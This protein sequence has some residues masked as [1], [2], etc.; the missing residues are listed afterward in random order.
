[1]QELENSKEVTIDIVGKD[2]TVYVL[3][4]SERFQEI[5]NQLNSGLEGA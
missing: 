4:K 2:K 3:L 1:M 5:I